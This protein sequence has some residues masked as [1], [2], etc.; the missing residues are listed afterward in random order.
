M[1]NRVKALFSLE[2]LKFRGKFEVINLVNFFPAS[3]Q[4]LF[5]PVEKVCEGSVYCYFVRF[6][7]QPVVMP[8]DVM[9]AMCVAIGS[10][11]CQAMQL[12][13]I[14]TNQFAYIT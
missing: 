5:F 2:E 11:D 6:E 3:L 12:F 10:A 9:A 14:V 8:F 4:K 13:D 1:Y 7:V